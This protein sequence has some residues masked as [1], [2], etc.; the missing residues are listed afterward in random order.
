MNEQRH[1]I[2]VDELSGIIRD[3]IG[4]HTAGSDLAEL[5]TVMS[6]GDGIARVSGVERAMAGGL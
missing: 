2:H 4:G 6:V 1:S 3:T 5:G